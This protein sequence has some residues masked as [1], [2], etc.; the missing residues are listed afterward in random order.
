[1][2][3][4]NAIE[5]LGGTNS[6]ICDGFGIESIDASSSMAPISAF[7]ASGLCP[8]VEGPDG[9]ESYLRFGGA[10]GDGGGPIG[11]PLVLLSSAP[12]A[13]CSSFSFLPSLT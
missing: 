12:W 9:V 3:R 5:G 1:V 7:G 13:S 10:I 4:C 6:S 11:S 8:L 2:L